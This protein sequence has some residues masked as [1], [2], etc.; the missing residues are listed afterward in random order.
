L[1]KDVWSVTVASLA[2]TLEDLR[3]RGSADAHVEV[4]RVRGGLPQDRFETV[5]AFV[6]SRG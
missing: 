2:G 3:R 6:N 1:S 4:K 5:S